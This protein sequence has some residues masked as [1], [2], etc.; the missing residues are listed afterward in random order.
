MR[1]LSKSELAAHIDKM[2]NDRSALQKE[3]ETVAK[4]RD[5]Y[6]RD[7]TKRLAASGKGDSFDE[8]VA[9]TIRAQAA[10]KGIRYEP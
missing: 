7:K 9:Q 1:E 3:I 6:I 2:R 5:E 4:E 8:K 10:K